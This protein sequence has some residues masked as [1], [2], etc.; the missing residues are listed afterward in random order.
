MRHSYSVLWGKS[1]HFIIMLFIQMGT[2]IKKR[3][4][5][6]TITCVLLS[7]AGVTGI[8]LSLL[9]RLVHALCKD[10]DEDVV[11]DHLLN[12]HKALSSL[13]NL[14]VQVLDPNIH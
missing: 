11:P 13:S 10:D 2:Y 5:V 7:F 12:I 1:Q 9:S 14:Q 4:L 6:L 8:H 3:A